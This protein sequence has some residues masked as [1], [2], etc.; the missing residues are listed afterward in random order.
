[1]FRS[2]PSSTRTDTL[3]PYPTLFRSGFAISM[4]TLFEKSGAEGAYR[5]FKFEIARIAER[6]PLPGYTVELEQPEGKRE[7][8]LRMR[9]R[10]Q[11]DPLPP[12][13]T[14]RR[15]AA[16]PQSAAAA[17]H[18]NG[19][20]RHPPADADMLVDAGGMIR[21]TLAGL[22]AQASAGEIAERRVG[23]EGGKTG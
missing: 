1:M 22:S 15:T 23:K 21:R 20:V 12:T 18:N 6:D 9:R 17:T 14:S 16:T 3:F 10:P 4:P 8:S 7:P 19:A 11:S 13:T 2:L 5:R